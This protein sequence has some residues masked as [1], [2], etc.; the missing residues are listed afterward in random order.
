MS[1]EKIQVQFKRLQRHYET[2]VKTYD[3]ASLL[4]LSHIL[5]IWVELKPVLSLTDPAFDKTIKF[6]TGAPDKKVLK[7]SSN[8]RYIYAYLPTDG[9]TTFASKGHL[10]SGPELEGNKDFTMGVKVKNTGESILLSQFCYISKALEQPYVKALE[11]EQ[12][13]RCNYNNWMSSEIVRLKYINEE[14]DLERFIISREMLIKRVAN[15][16]DG[17]HTSLNTDNAGTNKFDNPIKWLMYFK[18]GGLPLPYFLLLKIAQDIVSN[19]N[20]WPKIK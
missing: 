3:D 19:L 10:A 14:G 16:L 7:Q 13:R 17:S 6:F 9:V 18:C 8:C 20:K 11:N 4:D 5:R 15:I 1:I 2:S 12:V